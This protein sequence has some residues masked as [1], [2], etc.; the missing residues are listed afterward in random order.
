MALGTLFP[1]RRPLLWVL[2]AGLLTSC[3]SHAQP[4]TASAPAPTSTT[5][6]ISGPV[7]TDHSIVAL[8]MF[9]PDRGWAVSETR[10]LRTADGGTTWHNLSPTGVASFGYA[11]STSFLDDLHAWILVPNSDDRLQ[12]ILY[13]TADG[14]TTWTESPAPFGG[15]TLQFLDAK[16]GWMMAALG[17]GAGSMAV[18]F[19]QTTDSG[20]SWTQ[21]YTNDPI[22]VGAGDTL[23]LG[24]LKSGMWATSMQKAW[25]GGVTYAPG[26][27]YLFETADGGHTWKQSTV[28]APPGYSEAQ[29]ETPG[30]VFVGAK[31][32]YL[33]VHVTSQYGVLL[34]VY[35]S[36]DGGGTWKLSPAYVP[37]GR[38]SDFISE[39]AGFV[40]NGTRFFFTA[41]SARSWK[42]IEPDVTF[43]SAFAGM[44]FASPEVG[45][46]LW[47]D[48][49]GG[50]R[51]YRTSDG[52]QT[53]DRLP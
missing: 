45:Y 46:V 9:D 6:P 34:V 53:W 50:R 19:Y 7:V 14:G 41:D 30:P 29:L 4:A 47:D 5:V 37:M 10:I 32:A 17:A 38:A 39:T 28:D 2:I 42:T 3:S 1:L 16:Q 36:Q 24:G 25:V 51:L 44:D 15:G 40:W 52:A 22:Q 21:S 12:G 27:V 13:R 33:P 48:G 26:T 8:H 43:A 11:V 18:A 31:I 20:Q 35:V 49:D 23:P